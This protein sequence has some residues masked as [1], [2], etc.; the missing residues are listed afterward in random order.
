MDT[1]EHLNFSKKRALDSLEKDGNPINA[2]TSFLSDMT[3]EDETREHPALELGMMLTMGGNL[4][5]VSAMKDFI[6]GFN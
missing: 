1:K 2:W 4:S 5:T 6:E 3:N